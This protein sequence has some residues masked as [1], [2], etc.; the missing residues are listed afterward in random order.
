[1]ESVIKNCSNVD[2]GHIKIVDG[3]LNIKY[4]WN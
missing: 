4:Q 3:A 1:M 2:E